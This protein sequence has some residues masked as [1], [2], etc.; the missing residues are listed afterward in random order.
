METLVSKVVDLL[1]GLAWPAAVLTALLIFR[2]PLTGLLTTRS[3][4]VGTAG[5]QL[6]IPAQ[7]SSAP[8]TVYDVDKLFQDSNPLLK[9]YLEKIHTMIKAYLDE[10]K[11]YTT[12]DDVALLTYGLIDSFGALRIE[13]I[14]YLI[15]GSQI[16]ALHAIQQAGGHCS[17]DNVRQYY[18]QAAAAYPTTYATYTFD[19]WLSFLQL[20][21]LIEVAENWVKL[22]PDGS[23]FI[24]YIAARGYSLTRVN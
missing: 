12:L 3:I 11:K 7:S 2:I 10:R 9:P 8:V 13:R 24:P 1:T 21:E 4:K 16:S 20:N 22:T 5:I 18:V 14:N 6:E 15:F 19:Q 17:I 23:A